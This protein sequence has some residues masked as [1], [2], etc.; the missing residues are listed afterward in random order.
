[1]SDPIFN[2]NTF[3]AK[4]VAKPGQGG[5]AGLLTF[6]QGSADL[7][8]DRAFLCQSAQVTFSRQVQKSYFINVDGLAYIFGR[9]AGTLGLTGMLGSAEDFAV[10][11]GN[12]LA[13]PCKGLFTVKL[14]AFGMQ[15]CSDTEPPQGQLIM[16]GV[17]AQGFTITAAVSDATGA[18]WYTATANFDIANL[19]ITN[20]RRNISTA[21]SGR[22]LVGAF[23]TR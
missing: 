20:E 19:A 8:I 23:G 4:Y 5:F 21:I 9:G 12:D 11:F 17:V 18:L 16:T 1:M 14:D 15:S 22:S 7:P 10:L 13:N 2:S 6:S 3:T